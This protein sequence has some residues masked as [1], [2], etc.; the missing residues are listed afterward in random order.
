MVT[1]V[2]LNL[3]TGA[4]EHIQRPDLKF[5]P[6]H[7]ADAKSALARVAARSRPPTAGTRASWPH[8]SLVASPGVFS[9]SPHS[10][11]SGAKKRLQRPPVRRWLCLLCCPIPLPPPRRRSCP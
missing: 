10:A 11:H 7:I 6:D 8:S 1:D 2:V 4:I 3:D 9:S 5:A